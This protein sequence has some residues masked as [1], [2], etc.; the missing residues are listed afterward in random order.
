MLDILGDS[1][2]YDLEFEVVNGQVQGIPRLLQDPLSYRTYQWRNG[3]AWRAW[4]ELRRTTLL[5]INSSDHNPSTAPG[6][7][8]SD[9]PELQTPW[10]MRHYVKPTPANTP[11]AGWKSEGGFTLSNSNFNKTELAG[12]VEQFTIALTDTVH[13]VALRT[14]RIGQPFFSVIAPSDVLTPEQLARAAP[15]HEGSAVIGAL[16]DE[17][18]ALTMPIPVEFDAERIHPDETT[19]FGSEKVAKSRLA[20]DVSLRL[21]GQEALAATFWADVRR[22]QKPSRSFGDVPECAWDAFREVIPWQADPATRPPNPAR[23]RTSSCAR[24]IRW[25]ASA[26]GR[27]TRDQDQ[28]ELALAV[29]AGHRCVA[30]PPPASEARLGHSM[31]RTLLAV[32]C[33]GALLVT[34]ACGGDDKAAPGNQ[35]DSILASTADIVFQCRADERGLVEPDRRGPPAGRGRSPGGAAE[36]TSTS[37]SAAVAGLETEITLR[38]ADRARDRPAE[39]IRSRRSRRSSRASTA[40]A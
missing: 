27:G 21:I 40:R 39:G 14:L 7:R 35:V 20:L 22:A 26:T 12:N 19:T 17:L 3:A 6:T 37:P 32:L 28:A 36:S 25:T 31:K 30:G 11:Y 38:R 34:A 13:T 23:S 16:V 24:T 9:S 2:L 33:A 1:Y 18:Q 5:E 29:W 10:F 8:P 4:D 15:Q